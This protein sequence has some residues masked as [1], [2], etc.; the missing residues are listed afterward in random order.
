MPLDKTFRSCFSHLE[1]WLSSLAPGQA[2]AFSDI[3]DTPKTWTGRQVRQ[4]LQSILTLKATEDTPG[5]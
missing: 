5:A 3:R 4:E 1:S 2:G